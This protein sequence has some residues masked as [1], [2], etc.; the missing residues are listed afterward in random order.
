MTDQE[1]AD[2]SRDEA[3]TKWRSR[4]QRGA[5]AAELGPMTL[6]EIINETFGIYSG[7]FWKFVAIVAIV[8]GSIFVVFLVTF[9]AW[10]VAL[11]GIADLY[12]GTTW[13]LPLG[14]AGGLIAAGIA[15]FV[16]SIVGVALQQGALIHAVS[17]QTVRQTV[18]LGWAFSAARR[19]LVAMIATGLLYVLAT[20]AIIGIMV[21]ASLVS[22]PLA[23][24]GML[25]ALPVIYFFGVRWAFVLQ[26]IVIEGAGPIEAF[27]RSRSL[28]QGN[29]WRVFGILLVVG[30]IVGAITM[31]TGLLVLIP[32]LGW[33]VQLAVPILLA[34]I[35]VIAQTLLY[36][37]LRHRER[38][39]TTEALA[40]ELGLETTTE[41]GTAVGE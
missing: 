2:E 30:L 15:L 9:L 12:Y 17:E 35:M 37:D 40:N 29:W 24:L 13:V 5:K 41:L 14:A 31:T 23:I 33:V 38:G 36:F 8:E 22:W 26:V 3:V 19:R 1:P 20:S 39:F 4:Q 21:A 32:V 34:P 6:S 10:G 27:S 18:G 25:A 7:A 11:P 16:V 28:V